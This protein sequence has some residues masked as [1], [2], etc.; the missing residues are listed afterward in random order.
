MLCG[1]SPACHA[2]PVQHVMRLQSGIPVVSI[3]VVSIAVPVVIIAAVSI[4]AASCHS[5]P[6]LGRVE[7]K[8]LVFVFTLKFRKKFLLAFREK[9]FSFTQKFSRNFVFG[10]R[11]R[12]HKNISKAFAKTTIS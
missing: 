3:A 2:A 7:E 4:A 1:S 6:V 5:A 12:E 11:L 8:I 10:G 9:K